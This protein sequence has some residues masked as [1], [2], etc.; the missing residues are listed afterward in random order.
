MHPTP[1]STPKVVTANDEY[2]VG[3]NNGPLRR[4]PLPAAATHQPP[5]CRVDGN[6][7]GCDL[8]DGLPCPAQL[9][10]TRQSAHKEGSLR[11]ALAAPPH[12]LATPSGA[13]LGAD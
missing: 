8:R 2:E 6:N 1:A 9:P 4:Q 13:Q 12:T 10:Q 11:L 3:S 5:C 7:V